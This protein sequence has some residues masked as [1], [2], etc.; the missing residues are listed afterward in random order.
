M[1]VVIVIMLTMVTQGT[2]FFLGYR[3]PVG[4]QQLIQECAPGQAQLR[5]QAR[6]EKRAILFGQLVSTEQVRRQMIFFCLQPRPGASADN[7]QS[8]FG[9]D[10]AT[11]DWER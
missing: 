11:P 8:R 10:H 6:L 3:E 1:W 2:S 4:R 7:A 5:Q 9:A